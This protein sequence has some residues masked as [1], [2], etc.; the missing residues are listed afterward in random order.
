MKDILQYKN[1][2]DKV[3][4]LSK[5]EP[6][7][8]HDYP[9]SLKE[10]FVDLEFHVKGDPK[11]GRRCWALSG[12]QL[13]HQYRIMCMQYGSDIIYIANPV[14]IRTYGDASQNSE[15]CSSIMNGESNY[16]VRRYTIIKVKALR[17]VFEDNIPKFKP[18]IL[19]E[20]GLYSAI[21]QHE[22][23][24]MDGITLF[25]RMHLGAAKKLEDK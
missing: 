14:V 23:D 19:K 7:E 4:L 16:W 8:R 10:M 11:T 1:D 6:I 20:H 9:D 12:I 18:V 13:G 25:E 22:I 17:V 24:H 2:D 5:S 21:L 15:G 3:I